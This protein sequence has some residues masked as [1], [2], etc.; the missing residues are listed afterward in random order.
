[1]GGGYLSLHSAAEQPTTNDRR[2]IVTTTPPVTHTRSSG[3][4]DQ[5]S[6]VDPGATRLSC[7]TSEGRIDNKTGKRILTRPPPAS[8]HSW[9]RRYSWPE[10]HIKLST[11]FKRSTQRLVNRLQ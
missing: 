11:A 10:G 9:G 7:T 1:M 2:T 4:I 5:S 8:H 3:E 6:L